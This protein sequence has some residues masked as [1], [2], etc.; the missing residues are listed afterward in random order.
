MAKA[1]TLDEVFDVEWK[2]KLTGDTIKGSVPKKP[3]GQRPKRER[4]LHRRNP[5]NKKE[6]QVK[7]NWGNSG[8]TTFTT[9]PTPADARI[10]CEHLSVAPWR[11]EE[12]VSVSG[13]KKREVGDANKDDGAQ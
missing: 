4:M 2:D 3:R 1:K 5:D 10:V 9:C 12:T 11:R 6:V 7:W 13:R 8:W